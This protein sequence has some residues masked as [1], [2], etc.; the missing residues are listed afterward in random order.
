MNKRIKKKKITQKI[1]NKVFNTR[2]VVIDAY[3]TYNYAAELGYQL[4]APVRYVSYLK[5]LNLNKRNTMLGGSIEKKRK[6][7]EEDIIA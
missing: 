3:S 7:K 6:L 2:Q 4:K 5:R 1:S